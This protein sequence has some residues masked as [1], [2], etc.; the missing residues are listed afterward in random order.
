STTHLIL[1]IS[2]TSI[3]H[4]R[5]CIFCVKF[6]SRRCLSLHKFY[7]FKAPVGR[8][9]FP[10]LCTHPLLKEVDS[11]CITEVLSS[12]LRLYF[13]YYITIH[14]SSDICSITGASR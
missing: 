9:S 6:V 4:L 10:N 13:Y 3:T 5:R 1:H 7:T 12:G 14:P 2:Y 11:K 8:S